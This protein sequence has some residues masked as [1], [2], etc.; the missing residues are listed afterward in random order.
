[1][2]MV[3]R[4]VDFP[5]ISPNATGQTTIP[6]SIAVDGNR[7]YVVA[8]NLPGIVAT[9]HYEWIDAYDASNPADP[10]WTGAVEGL[11][12]D[13]DFHPMQTFASGGFLWRVTSPSFPIGAGSPTSQVAFYDA[14]NGQP[15]LKQL[16]T[17]PRMW[18]YSSFQGLLVGIPGSFTSTGVALWQSP[19]T[20]F[21]FDDRSGTPVTSQIPLV[22]PNP[23]T[24]ISIDGIAITDTRVF[25]F[26]Q[27][28]QS[29]G[30]L[31]FF[32][33]TYNLT[34]NPPTLLQTVSAQPPP[35]TLAP[36][37]PAARVF[38]NLLYAGEGVYDITSGLPVLLAPLQI[39]PVDVSGT[40]GI[41]GPG[42][43]TEY[44]LIDN[45]T[46]ANPKVTGI[47]YSGDELK[48]TGRLVGNHAYMVG[49]GI[50]IYDLTGAGG[51]IPH[52]ILRSGG[53]AV[54]TDLLVASSNLYAAEAT[55]L[56]PLVMSFDLSQ[57]PPQKAGSFALGS[58]TPFALAASSHFLF[59]ATST[60]LLVLDASNPSA[61][62]KVTSLPL[63]TSSLALVGNTLYAGTTDN[64]LVVL[65]VT[66]PS[67]PLQ[68]AAI[69]LA[70]FPV[71]MRAN[72]SL[73]LIAADTAGLLT[74]SIANPSAPAF[75]SQ[76]Q[77]SS[78]VEGVASD[79]PLA[80]LAAT[81]GG[82]VIADMTNPAA[83]VLAGQFPLDLLSCFA[84]LDPIDGLP[85]LITISSNNGI[86]YLGTANM[87][88][89]VFGIDYRQPAHP[90]IVSAAAYGGG[91]LGS[92]FSFAFSGSNLFLAG[93]AVNDVVE[94]DVTQPRNF[95]RHMCFPPPFG[96]NQGT[97]SP[98][99]V[100]HVTGL[101]T[102]NPKAHLG[103]LE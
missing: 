6:K 24:G 73:L 35:P 7:V 52:Q 91:I 55:D 50:Q 25:L 45:S 16:F 13:L 67:S 3:N 1:M 8:D 43:D 88:G 20:A 26:F 19:V 42:P 71:A 46:P 4:L 29:Y 95:I 75:V 9:G 90:R 84:D 80:L 12:G 99:L 41:A 21:V 81:D 89:R 87:F 83:P 53:G 92:I 47:L 78:A 34:S 48:G 44:S 15:A 5:D 58:E 57:T 77:P 38:G 86:A 62:T 66:N 10:A 36:T 70:G 14:S 2:G 76:F 11:D 100:K 23:S 17:V 49:T 98:E 54:A 22:L 18:V 97:V 59:V 101:S 61:L 63:P 31:P 72:G 33:S 96:P 27:Q 102:W 94:A 30:S 69:S 51:Q 68:G 56:G 28:Q 64:R 93:D 103:K 82:F 79:G 40:L 37:D 32:L 85:G 65:D 39:L 60:E 74:Y